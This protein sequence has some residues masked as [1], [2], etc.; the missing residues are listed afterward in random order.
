MGW[1]VGRDR[2]VG[3]APGLRHQVREGDSHPPARPPPLPIIYVPSHTSTTRS[4]YTTQD[5]PGIYLV[6]EHCPGGDLLE[7]LLHEGR[8][9]AEARVAAHV[10][11][12]LLASLAAL[13]ALHVVH[14]DVKL[15]N[16]FIGAD[17]G[18]RLGDYGLTMSLKQELAISPVGTV[19]YMA[20]EA[21][22]RLAFRDSMVYLFCGVRGVV[23]G[24]RACGGP[25]ARPCPPTP[26][27]HPACH[28]TNFPPARTDLLG[29]GAA[30]GG[31]GDVRRGAG[32]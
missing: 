31:P 3:G 32:V 19:E 8:A 25:C 16:V 1:R 17:G 27:T 26:P 18:V 5:G 20:P 30:A 24:G 7:R 22:R 9:M 13:H 2:R 12:P 21:C 15:E 29:R 4:T 28:P 10:A 23:E 6:M 11:A 14:R